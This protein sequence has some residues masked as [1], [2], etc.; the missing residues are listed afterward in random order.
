[1]LMISLSLA[2]LFPIGG[3]DIM[4]FLSFKLLRL[5]YMFEVD[6]FNAGKRLSVI[7][8]SRSMSAP[9]TCRVGH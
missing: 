3:I 1:M 6:F 2:L 4:N 5:L 9:F 7:A 8:S